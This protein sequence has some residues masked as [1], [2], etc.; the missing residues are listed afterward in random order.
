MICEKLRYACVWQIELKTVF[1]KRV[2][3]RKY[4]LEPICDALI[5]YKKRKLKIKFPLFQYAF[6]QA[7]ILVRIFV[8]T[9]ELTLNALRLISKHNFR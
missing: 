1:A 7:F 9:S 3:F 4:L 6:V 2:A 5:K 8:D